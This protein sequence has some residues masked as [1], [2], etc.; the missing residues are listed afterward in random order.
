MGKDRIAD[1][2]RKIKNGDVEDWASTTQEGVAIEGI[3]NTM[4]TALLNGKGQGGINKVADYYREERGVTD[5]QL[6]EARF[7]LMIN[8]VRFHW[9]KDSSFDL[10][11]GRKG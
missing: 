11:K 10:D 8:R 9:D 6:L 7:R 1:I 5:E 4:S 2:I 3:V